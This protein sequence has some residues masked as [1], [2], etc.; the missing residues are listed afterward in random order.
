MSTNIWDE[1]N[2]PAKTTSPVRIRDSKS[3]EEEPKSASEAEEEEHNSS[4]EPKEEEPNSASEPE[5]EEPNSTS[6]PEEEANSEQEQEYNYNNELESEARP[7]DPLEVFETG[8]AKVLAN[9]NVYMQPRGPLGLSRME[10]QV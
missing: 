4:S 10:T 8:M 2:Q 1:S 3:E 5:E 6:E 9:L 7:D